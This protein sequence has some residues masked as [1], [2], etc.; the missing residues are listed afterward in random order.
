MIFSEGTVYLGLNIG[1]GTAGTCYRPPYI[2]LDIE[3]KP[4]YMDSWKK[5]KESGP[6]RFMV[7]DCTKLPFKDGVF[8]EIFAGHVLEHFNEG[9]IVSVL[10][11]WYRVIKKGGRI[12]VCIPDFE[13]AV[14]IY[15]GQIQWK[16]YDPSGGLVLRKK[17]V[18]HGASGPILRNIY[19]HTQSDPTK[20]DHL[21]SFDFESLCWYMGR[22]GFKNMRRAKIHTVIYSRTGGSEVCVVAEK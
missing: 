3:T 16:D 12:K 18:I 9:G 21:M 4:Q 7:A 5:K 15:L 2:N 13:F 11:E 22:A 10:K 20:G 19:G 1:C 14:K 6:M 8:N 17:G